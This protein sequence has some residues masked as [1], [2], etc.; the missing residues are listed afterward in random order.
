MTD[1]LARLSTARADRYEI[2]EEIG[3]AGTWMNIE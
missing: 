3:A 2:Q 1:S